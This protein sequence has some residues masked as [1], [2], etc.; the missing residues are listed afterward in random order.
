MKLAR[1]LPVV[2]IVWIGA[3]ANR[4]RNVFSLE[5]L[6]YAA[7]IVLPSWWAAAWS[8][9]PSAGTELSTWECSG[10]P[11]EPSRPSPTE[12]STHD[13]PWPRGRH[14]RHD[15]RLGFVALLTGPWPRLPVRRGRKCSRRSRRRPGRDEA[16]ARRPVAPDL[17]TTEGPGTTRVTEATGFCH[18][19]WPDPDG[20]EPVSGQRPEHN[21][22]LGG[23]TLVRATPSSFV[24]DRA[25]AEFF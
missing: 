15:R 16:Q 8:S 4:L 12:T 10:G 9:S 17:G 7:L 3:V 1:V 21:V 20:H 18:P 5:G 19:S 22:P 11:P 2:R 25:W 13:G 24:G 23:A 6:R 14:R